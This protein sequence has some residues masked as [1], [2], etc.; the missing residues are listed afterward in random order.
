M[1]RDFGESYAFKVGCRWDYS[2]SGAKRQSVNEIIE[3]GA[4]RIRFSAQ[5]VQKNNLHYY[6][7][8]R[9]QLAVRN[10][11]LLLVLMGF[12]GSGGKAA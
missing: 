4:L 3:L 11:I 9:R 2:Q 5:K 8:P 1:L 7:I 6:E 10:D 12:W